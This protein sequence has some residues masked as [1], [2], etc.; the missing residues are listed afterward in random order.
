[1]MIR[2]RDLPY[3]S[4]GEGVQRKILASGGSLMTMEVAFSKGG[5]GSIH[6]HPHQQ[7]SYLVHGRIEYR[8]GDET[9]LLEAGDSCYVPPDTLHGVVALEDALL[10][11]VFTPQRKDLLE[12]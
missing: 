12:H 3:Q 8:I 4:A 9:F 10:L 11:D 2:N 1:M 5:V 6:S 7:I